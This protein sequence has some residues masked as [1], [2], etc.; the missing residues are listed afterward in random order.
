MGLRVSVRCSDAAAM[1]CAAVVALLAAVP[2]QAADAEGA[3]PSDSSAG[4]DAAAGAT[5]PAR[6]QNLTLGFHACS[7]YLLEVS[8]HGGGF[9]ES[10]SLD[11]YHRCLWVL[12]HAR[13]LPREVFVGGQHYPTIVVANHRDPDMRLPPGKLPRRSRQRYSSIPLQPFSDTQEAFARAELR[14]PHH[15]V[16]PYFDVNIGNI[17]KNQGSMNHYQSYQMQSMLRPGDTVVD[18]GGNLGCY[19]IPFAEAVGR[20]GRVFAF[21]PF[22]WMHQQLTAN[23]AINGLQ[24]VWP[25][26]AALGRRAEVRPLLP[27][28]LRFFSSPGGLHVEG[29]AEQVRTRPQNE[30]F[31]LYD[32][33]ASEAERVRVVRLDDLLLN[34]Q[35]GEMW[36]LPVP[37]ADVRLIKIDAEGMEVAIIEGAAEAIR[38]FRPIVWSENNAYFDSN[39]KDTAFLEVMAGLGY[40]CARVESAPG[41][42]VCTDQSGNGHS[43]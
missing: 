27:P 43:F 6:D 22:R 34:P 19:T 8:A 35:E 21:E 1:G 17:I 40:G 9:W 29:Q 30:V 31:Q 39:G 2:G 38:S 3:R 11:R 12:R 15:F 37:I 25:V 28:Q 36:G 20:A 42:V 10:A 26:Q 23:V 32:L 4:D 41:D 33:L 13:D 14:V 16:L 7:R 24:N 18:V 5:A